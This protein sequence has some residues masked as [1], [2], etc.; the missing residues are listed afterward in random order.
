MVI[1]RPDS[2]AGGVLP[3]SQQTDNDD[4]EPQRLEQQLQQQQ[5]F[6]RKAIEADYIDTIQEL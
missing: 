3:S 2:V 6:Q 1:D 5:R 4:F